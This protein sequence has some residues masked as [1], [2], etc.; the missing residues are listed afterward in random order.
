M[1]RGSEN[2]ADEE[3]LRFNITAN[4]V[5]SNTLDFTLDFYEPELVGIGNRPD[6][7]TMKVINADFF[8][9]QKSGF[10]IPPGYSVSMQLPKMLGRSMSHA[11]EYTQTAVE[12]T[13]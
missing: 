3:K 1:I 7:L 5:S 11:V 10:T 4:G 13:M 9:S 12:Y 2:S 8:G 6:F